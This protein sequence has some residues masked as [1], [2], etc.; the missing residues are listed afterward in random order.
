[1]NDAVPLY[2]VNVVTD[3]FTLLFWA[4]QGPGSAIQT[5]NIKRYP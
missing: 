4:S 2:V 5:Q 1:M 3:D